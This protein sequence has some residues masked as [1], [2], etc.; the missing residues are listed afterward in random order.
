MEQKAIEQQ[1]KL[2]QSMD[3]ISKIGDEQLLAGKKLRNNDLR[4]RKDVL[5][6]QWCDCQ[7]PGRKNIL[8]NN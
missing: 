1:G 5:E 6:L 2:V 3:R 8:K 4:M 7:D